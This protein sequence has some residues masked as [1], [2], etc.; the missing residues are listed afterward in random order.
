[1]EN[2][3]FNRTKL[4][5]ASMMEVYSIRWTIEVL[6]KELKQHLWFCKCNSRDFDA[7]IASVTVSLILYVFLSY[8]RRINA[9][10]PLGG[11]F[12]AIKDEICEKNLAQ[13]LWELLDELLQVVIEAIAE[14]G[15]VNITDFKS[16]PEYQ[17][18]KDLFEKSFLSNQILG[19]N[20]A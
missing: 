19:I 13:R 8:Y 10:E 11:L 1:M 16:S 12:E 15:S 4:N 17:Y 20:A 2:F 14:S 9:Y 6:F 3:S 18:L 5:F 7:Q